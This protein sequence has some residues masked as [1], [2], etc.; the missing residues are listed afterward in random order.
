MVAAVD[1]CASWANTLLFI[2]VAMPKGAQSRTAN[3]VELP[4]L[5]REYDSEYRRDVADGTQTEFA[6]VFSRTH[7][8]DCW[9]HRDRHRHGPVATGRIYPGPIC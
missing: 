3:I 9:R 1:G 6:T 5:L 8:H 4:A 7:H 2:D